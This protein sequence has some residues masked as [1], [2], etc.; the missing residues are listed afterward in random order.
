[1]RRGSIF[2]APVRGVLS[3]DDYRDA[4]QVN[5]DSTG[6]KISVQCWN[7]VPKILELDDFMNSNAEARGVLRESHPEVCFAM[8]NR[9][10]S[11]RNSKKT[12]AGETERRK[13]LRSYDPHCG[14]LIKE[15]LDS[16]SRNE[17]VVDDVLDA[18]VLAVAAEGEEYGDIKSFPT[19]KIFDQ[20]GLRMEIA[21]RD[22][23][24]KKGEKL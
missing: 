4:C 24:G 22:R 23:F 5:A 8:M 6:K 7:I 12:K 18:A 21:Y 16:R 10:V 13:L 20:K 11:M 17:L 3:C 15:C 1:M 2:N 19:E 9:G 14:T